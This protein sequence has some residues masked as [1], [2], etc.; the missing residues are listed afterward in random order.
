VSSKD[1]DES[2]IQRF[3][4]S[5][6]A[7][8]AV[9]IYLLLQGNTVRI[10]PKKL[11]AKWEDRYK[12]KDRGDL[13]VNNH[14]VEVKGLSLEFEMNQWPFPK[15]LICSKFSFDRA[16]PRPDYYFL[17]NK[18]MTVAAIVDVKNTMHKWF[19]I[20]QRDPARGE[21]YEAYAMDPKLLQWRE[22]K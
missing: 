16:E 17:V 12:F 8:N 11:R 9:G 21:V 7:E 15:T 19:V 13:I 14:R 4:G 3:N 1:W 10:N 2:F 6:R 5:S 20:N 22:L 18:A